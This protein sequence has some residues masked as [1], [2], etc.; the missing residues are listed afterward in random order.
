MGFP[1]LEIKSVATSGSCVVSMANSVQTES[2]R[3]GQWK[4][5]VVLTRMQIFSNGAGEKERKIFWRGYITPILWLLRAYLK[6]RYIRLAN[7]SAIFQILYTLK[8]KRIRLY[9]KKMLKYTVSDIGIG[10]LSTDINAP[11]K[12]FGCFWVGHQ[13]DISG[14]GTVP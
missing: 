7:I 11:Y 4:L 9:S 10:C 8:N 2:E 12:F 6:N 14:L 1:Q 3:G 13:E 5:V